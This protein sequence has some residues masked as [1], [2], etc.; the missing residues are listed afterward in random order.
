MPF[1]LRG[2]EL[3]GRNLTRPAY[4]Y[5]SGDTSPFV[6]YTA[7]QEDVAYW[8]MSYVVIGY[9]AGSTQGPVMVSYTIT[10]VSGP[11]ECTSADPPPP[12]PDPDPSPENCCD[13]LRTKI[14]NLSA[15][16]NSLQANILPKIDSLQQ[17]INASNQKINNIESNHIPKNEKSEIIQS[18]FYQSIQWAEPKFALVNNE[19]NGWQALLQAISA[20]LILLN[21]FLEEIK[22]GADSFANWVRAEFPK[23]QSYVNEEVG[24]IYQEINRNKPKNYDLEIAELRRLLDEVSGTAALARTEAK[25]VRTIAE[26]AYELAQATHNELLKFKDFIRGA[27]ARLEAELKA[28]IAY[29]IQRALA[30]MQRLEAFIKSELAFLTLST[31]NAMLKLQT[32]IERNESLIKDAQNNADK[33]IRNANLAINDIKAIKPNVQTALD[34]ATL[35]IKDSAKAIELGDINSLKTIDLR[36]RLGAIPQQIKDEIIPKIP[37]VAEEYARKYGAGNMISMGEIQRGYNYS[38]DTKLDRLQKQLDAKWNASLREIDLQSNGAFDRLNAITA[39][40]EKMGQEFARKTDLEY[41]VS[42]YGGNF[43]PAKTAELQQIRARESAELRAGI[44]QITKFQADVDQFI[45]DKQS[46]RSAY[47]EDARKIAIPEI[48]KKVAPVALKQADTDK[49]IADI[50]K[51]LTERESVDKE[52]NEKLKTI[53]P[54]LPELS[55]KLDRITPTILGIPAIVGKIPDQTVGKIPNAISPLIPTIPQ[56]G[57]V[58]QDKVCNPQ[59]QLPSISAGN[60]ATNAVNQAK[61]D[62]GDKIDKT[63]NAAQTGM[64]VEILSRLGD[65]IPGGLSGKLVDGFKWLHLDRVLNVLTFIATVQNHLMLSN[66]IG[67]TLIGA[68]NNGLQLIGLKDDKQQPINVGQIISGTIEN[69]IK[70]IVGTENYATLSAQWAK[71][72]RIYQASTNVLNSFLGLTQTVLQAAEMIAAY[73]GKIG[74]ALRKGGVVLENAYGLMNPQ[75]KFNRVTQ[76]LESLQNGASTIQM[77]TQVPLDVVN[78]TTEL[79]TASTEFVKAIKEDTPANKATP[80]P[81][82][83]ELKAKETQAKADSQP[84]PFDFSDL[85]DGED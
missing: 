78:A 12:P 38:E 81:E 41:F 18:A 48:D 59:C 25:D 16:L 77:V 4:Y 73:T 10:P 31:L 24:K 47:R 71:A 65:K 68:I 51:R 19:I 13:E 50:K 79:T 35:A 63:N 17:Q 76:T 9:Q 55:A 80:I 61:N 62:L 32:R 3:A 7:S 14:Q 52:V 34:K 42:Q 67:Q 85:F 54:V 72:N 33:A 20:S 28:D 69:L 84:S 23:L 40:T 21:Q 74:N 64:L 8:G 83:D 6:T 2:T 22:R 75:P 30:A 60:N 46:E 1:C 37:P 11:G 49:E 43:S 57:D 44:N 39:A 15:Q 58:V 66:D 70:G 29:V 27:L 5:F 26:K 45:N 82:P 36:T 53:T 56:I